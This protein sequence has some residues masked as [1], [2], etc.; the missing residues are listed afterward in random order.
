MK[1]LIIFFFSVAVFFVVGCGDGG[2]RRH[3]SPQP[4]HRRP[5][6]VHPTRSPV[7]HPPVRRSPV[8]HPP[9]HRHTVPSHRPMTPPIRHSGPPRK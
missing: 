9:V 3:Y 1:K 7:Y 8:Y 5:V 2:G 4:V 6:V